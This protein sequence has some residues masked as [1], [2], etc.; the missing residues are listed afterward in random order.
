MKYA[1]TLITLLTTHDPTRTVVDSHSDQINKGEVTK[2]TKKHT[3]SCWIVY[4]NLSRARQ[5]LYDKS[6][7]WRYVDIYSSSGPKCK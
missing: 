5:K 2:E 1:P 6:D 7:C 4:C 3:L